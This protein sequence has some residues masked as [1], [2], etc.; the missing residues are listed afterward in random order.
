MRIIICEDQPSYIQALTAHI[1]VWIKQK[2]AFDA[3]VQ[4]FC[5][6]E[7]LL[8]AWNSGIKADVF[9]LD[10]EFKG[11]LDGMH[12]AQQIRQTDEYVPIVFITNHDAYWREGF[13]VYALRYLSKPVT[14]DDVA[15]CLDIAYQQYKVSKNE[16]F[17]ITD[18]GRKIAL[19]YSE[20]LYLEAHTPYTYIHLIGNG[21]KPLRIR[22]RFSDAINALPTELFIQT[23]RSYSVNLLH[24]RC[25][26]KTDVHLSNGELLPISKACVNTVNAAFDK[27][28]QGDGCV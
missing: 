12:V 11:E 7:D 24:V 17:M 27:Y 14:Y 21:E 19:R 9:F 6:S 13:S 25:I 1:D 16:H 5:S 26:T 23:H 20:I 15:T 28:Y 4:S 18:A 10:I 22:Y 2:G 3:S 8:D